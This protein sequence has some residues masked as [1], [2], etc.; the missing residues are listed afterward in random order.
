MIIPV[1]VGTDIVN[2]WTVLQNSL[3]L[4]EGNVFTRLQFYEVFLAICKDEMKTITLT[5]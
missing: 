4:S 1:G 5:V 2:Q 3:H